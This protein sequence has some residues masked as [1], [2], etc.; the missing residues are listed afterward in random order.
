MGIAWVATAR[1]P[2]RVSAPP[3]TVPE[4]ADSGAFAAS[5]GARKWQASA[6][7]AGASGSADAAPG[8]APVVVAATAAALVAGCGRRRRGS[9]VARK[10]AGTE[11]ASGKTALLELRASELKRELR[12]RGL[13][14]SASFDREALLELGTSSGVLPASAARPRRRVSLDGLAAP[15]TVAL[16]RLVSEEPYVPSGPFSDGERV[17]L[18]LWHEVDSARSPSWFLLD[19]AIR[20]SVLSASLAERIATRVGEQTI[21]RGLRFAGEPVRELQV[22]VAPD[23]SVVLGTEDARADGLLGLDFLHAWDIDLDISRRVCRAWRAGPQLA[24]F[25]MSFGQQDALEVPLHGS[26]GLLEVRVR[27]RGTVCSGTERTGPP[28]RALVDLG[29]TYSACNWAAAQQ[30]G[31]REDGPCVRPAGQWLDLQGRAMN[32]FEAEMG[33]E[34]HGRASGVLRGVRLCEQRRFWLAESLPLLERLGFRPDEP[35]AILGLDTV[36]RS[37]LGISARHRRLWIPQ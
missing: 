7:T 16:R 18:P 9:T 14:T 3:A 35:C 34:I 11:T 13:D 29:Q 1:V 22:Q 12:A 24:G 27:L 26:Q 32:V 8:K 30:V 17:A 5:A 2:S 25:G 20:R 19:T 31:V 37:R 23:D 28:L 36:G 15:V 4:V 21:V 10:Y 6:N 33:V